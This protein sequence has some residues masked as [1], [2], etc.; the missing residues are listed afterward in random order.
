MAYG[1]RF[2]AAVR[3]RIRSHNADLH[4]LVRAIR[5]GRIR[6]RDELLRIAA[7][8]LYLAARRCRGRTR[9]ILFDRAERYLNFSDIPD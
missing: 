5:R 4:R 8:E 6:T 1:K 3:E 2:P 7:R 9:E